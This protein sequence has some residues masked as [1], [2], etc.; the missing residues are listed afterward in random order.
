MRYSR[1]SYSLILLG[2]TFQLALGTSG[3]WSRRQAAELMYPLLSELCADP[4]LDGSSFTITC[5]I[6]GGFSKSSIDLNTCLNN[7]DGVL[8]FSYASQEACSTLNSDTHPNSNGS[9]FLTCAQCGLQDFLRLTCNCETQ[10]QGP[11]STQIDLSKCRVHR[12]WLRTDHSGDG[13]FFRA[14]GQ[15]GCL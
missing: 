15:L 4:E 13:V 6:G 9:A 10:D 14:D 7:D 2:T 5:S 11:A 3:S 8:G 12:R 1:F